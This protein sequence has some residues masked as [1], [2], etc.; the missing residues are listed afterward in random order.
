MILHVSE[1]FKETFTGLPDLTKKVASPE[2]WG[3][4]LPENNFI[5]IFQFS[6]KLQELHYFPVR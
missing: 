2:L 3:R 5:V 1:E 4:S 6:R